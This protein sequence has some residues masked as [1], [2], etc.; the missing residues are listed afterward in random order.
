MGKIV[1]VVKEVRAGYCKSLEKPL[2]QTVFQLPIKA[3][4][5]RIIV[6]NK[7]NLTNHP[8]EILSL[9][10]PNIP[11]TDIKLPIIPTGQGVGK[12]LVLIFIKDGGLRTCNK[13]EPT[14]IS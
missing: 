3:D 8:K 5:E 1:K 12:D 14:L 9:L 13:Q 4:K 10:Y 11:T 7:D 6:I 2:I